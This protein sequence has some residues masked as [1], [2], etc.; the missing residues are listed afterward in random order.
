LIQ[1]RPGDALIGSICCNFKPL[2]PNTGY[3]KGVGPKGRRLIR[4][5]SPIR[6]CEH[7]LRRHILLVLLLGVVAAV[8]AMG[9]HRVLSLE[10]LVG[11]RVAIDSFVH[12]QSVIAVLAYIALYAAVTAG[13]LPAGAVLAVAGGF[14][15]GTIVGGL[16][17]TLGSTLG[18][19]TL[20]L[21]SRGA[22]GERFMRRAGSRWAAFAAGFR[23]DAFYYILFLRL[24][25]SPS[26]ATSM[27][28]GS[29]GVRP[30]VFVA[31]TALGRLPG[32]LIFA[33]FGSGFGSVIAAREVA[34]R[35]CLAADGDDCRV[36][37]NPADVLTPALLAGFIG[38]ALLA[39]LPVIA[40]RLLMRRPAPIDRES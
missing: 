2:H 32:S 34:Y 37:F 7:N 9:W 17:A 31:A 13:A 23:A 29:L 25:P 27:A 39:L 38:L 18:A 24:V 21:L 8:Y 33:L 3:H 26:W 15:F 35:A 10:T 19:T 5:G 4:E 12:N 28:A 1:F 30:L 11:N 40:R 14:L 16:G 6:Q 22:F 36:D 20:F